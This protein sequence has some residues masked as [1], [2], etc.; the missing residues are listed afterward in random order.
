MKELYEKYRVKRKEL[1]TVIEEPKEMM[2]AKRAKVKE[3][4]Q[5]FEQFSQ[6][7]IFNLNQKKIYA[8]LNKNEIWSNDI[9]NAEEF[10]KFWGNI[11]EVRKEHNREAE[12][13]KDLK[14]ER[15]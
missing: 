12:W 11:W 7:R 8:E 10:T 3:Y 14:R 2:L 1:K 15:E 6:N 5:K 13:L 9:L 4:G